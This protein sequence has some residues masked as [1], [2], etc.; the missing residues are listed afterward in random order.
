MDRLEAFKRET[1]PLDM[2]SFRRLAEYWS[3]DIAHDL[4]K[5]TDEDKA[6]FVELFDLQATILPDKSPKGY[7]INISAN[8]PL[9]MEGD[10]PSAYD[11]VFSP[12]GGG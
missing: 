2:A 6:R 9:E 8:V 4:W 11:M 7:H 3:G 5:A 10:R 12:S 1:P